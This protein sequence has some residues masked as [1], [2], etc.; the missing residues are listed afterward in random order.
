MPPEEEKSLKIIGYNYDTYTVMTRNMIK[1]GLLIDQYSEKS[2]FGKEEAN[3]CYILIR[4]HLMKYP[5][6]F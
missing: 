1:D 6:I 2:L 5:Y 4:F 3:I